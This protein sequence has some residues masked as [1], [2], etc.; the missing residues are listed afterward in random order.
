[1][2]KQKSLSDKLIESERHKLVDG[3]WLFK[4]DVKETAL[5]IL[6]RVDRLQVDCATLE[7]CNKEDV[8]K[9]IKEEV[10]LELCEHGGAE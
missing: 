10:G 6:E 9:I 3:F 7:I 8:E 5:R 4:D 1:M 2:E